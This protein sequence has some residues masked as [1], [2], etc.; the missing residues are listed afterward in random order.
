MGALAVRRRHG[1]AEI[2]GL[3]P[4]LLAAFSKRA[5]QVDAETDARVEEFEAREGRAPS[6]FERAAI[7]REASADTRVKKTGTAAAELRAAWRK[8]A[9]DLGK[10]KGY[11]LF[12]TTEPEE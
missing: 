4:E 6:R 10:A 8:E 3:D 5:A 1:Q 11:P 2:A 9:T 12:F 7:E